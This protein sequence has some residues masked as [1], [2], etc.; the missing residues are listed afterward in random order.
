MQHTPC[1]R[2]FLHA[3]I[4][5]YFIAHPNKTVAACILSAAS[6]SKSTGGI[7]SPPHSFELLLEV[8]VTSLKA[9][10]SRGSMKIT[11]ELVSSPT[12]Q[13]GSCSRLM[14]PKGVGVVKEASYVYP[15]GNMWNC[16]FQPSL[17]PGEGDTGDKLRMLLASD[18]LP[19]KDGVLMRLVEAILKSLGGGDRGV[20][21]VIGPVLRGEIATT[22][23]LSM[24]SPVSL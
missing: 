20:W 1:I 11:P 5:I 6:N 8:A 16:P 19:D 22:M 3:L 10:G 15:F 23:V 18:I 12:P 7:A 21:C 9:G 24:S 2:A 13:G 17:D 4:C 14:D